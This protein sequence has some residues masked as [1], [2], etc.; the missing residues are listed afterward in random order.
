MATFFK[1]AHTQPQ[2]LC[3]HFPNLIV[4]SEDTIASI[5]TCPPTLRQQR[6]V[7]RRK[8]IATNHGGILFSPP[9]ARNNG[10]HD[11]AQ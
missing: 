10:R 11:L 9:K 3:S 1:E 2:F 7:K 8:V 4:D 5:Q 6:Y